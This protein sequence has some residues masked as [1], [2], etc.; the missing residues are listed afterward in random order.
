MQGSEIWAESWGVLPEVPLF[1]DKVTGIKYDFNYGFRCHSPSDSMI[2][3]T[4]I[5]KHPQ[6]TCCVTYPL[7]PD[8]SGA[9]LLSITWTTR[10]R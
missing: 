8:A 6:A 3:L 2:C 5:S 9:F 10:L 7:P 1:E 4:F